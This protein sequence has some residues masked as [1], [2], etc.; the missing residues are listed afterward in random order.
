MNPLVLVHGLPDNSGTWEKLYP[1]LASKFSKISIVG[2]PGIGDSES[3]LDC[4]SFDELSDRLVLRLP[5]EPSIYIGHDFG[6][7]LGTVIAEKYPHLISKLVL[8]NAP[9]P[10]ILR[11]TIANDSDQAARSSYAIKIQK[12]PI[13]ILKKNDFAFLKYY[14][15]KNENKLSDVYKA[16]LETMWSDTLTLENIGQYYNLILNSELK[17]VGNFNQSLNQIWSK[18]DPFLGEVVKREMREKFHSNE[19]VEIQSESHWLQKSNP[20]ML[21]EIIYSSIKLKS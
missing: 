1:L 10:D 7:I 20:E 17:V 9:T 11:K 6:G 19:F 14:L 12:D 5:K 21:T 18:C 8:I 2:L 13:Q 3:I 4:C 15:F 16:S